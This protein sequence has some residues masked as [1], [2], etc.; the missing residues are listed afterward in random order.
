FHQIIPIIE[1]GKVFLPHQAIWL[2]DFEYE[3]LMFPF[4]VKGCTNAE[5]R[6]ANILQYF[7]CCKIGHS[8]NRVVCENLFSRVFCLHV[9]LSFLQN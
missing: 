2:N 5:L 3:I 4:S 1:S 6:T 9:F 7:T 8:H